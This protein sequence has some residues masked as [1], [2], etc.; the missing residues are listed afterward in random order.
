MY[1]QTRQ[2]DCTDKRAEIEVYWCLD[3]EVQY[4]EIAV[5]QLIES[6]KMCKCECETRVTRACGLGVL[7]WWSPL[8]AMKIPRCHC[9]FQRTHKPNTRGSIHNA[10]RKFSVT[11]W[12]KFKGNVPT[13]A[14]TAFMENTA[15]VGSIG[16]YLYIYIAESVTFSFF[17]ITIYLALQ[18]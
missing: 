3:K 13:L 7:M 8:K 11:A 9:L 15:Y 14:E 12:L 2:V 6:N 17:Y 10:S 1:R 5:C 16:N 4:N 18:I